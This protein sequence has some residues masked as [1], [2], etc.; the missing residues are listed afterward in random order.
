MQSMTHERQ[1]KKGIVWSAIERFSIQGVQFFLSI[2][3]ARLI[4]PSAFGLIA[5]IGVFTAIAQTFVDSG[6][7]SALIQKQKRK[8]EDYSTVFYFNII[9]GVGIC[10]LFILSA[11]YIASFYDEP[12]LEKLARWLSLNLIINALSIIHRTKLTILLDFK[13]QAIASLISVVI[14]GVLGIFFAYNGYG[15]WALVIQSLSYSGINTILLWFIVKWRP[16]FIFSMDSFHSL[17]KF[18]SKLLIG[19]IMHTLYLNLYTLAIGKMFSP[20][21]VGYYNRANSLAVFP[22]LNITN[23]V[24]RVSYPMQSRIQDD[25][26]ELKKS[27]IQNIRF[28]I[29]IISPIM[30]I[31]AVLSKPFIVCILTEK[32]LPAAEL[33]S[34]LCIAYMWQ[35]IMYFNWQL[36]NVKG[37]SDLSLKSEILKKSLALLILVITLPWGIKVMC[38]GLLLYSFVDM[39][40]I[41]FFIRKVIDVSYFEQ[42]NNYK[43]IIGLSL[44]TGIIVFLFSNLVDPLWIKLI[45][46]ILVGFAFY[47]CCSYLFQIKELSYFIQLFKLK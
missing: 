8:D 9:V 39:G 20:L 15:V 10:V 23:I 43:S 24:S 42:L 34:I 7:S 22:S 19:G 33:L 37:R 17:F 38:W 18:G 3:L 30:V 25:S 45:G 6:F 21:E 46:G 27:F 35:P 4:L 14:S 41:F 28:S 26:S 11:P 5:M 16:L 32:W 12:I 31:L 40:I 2:V 29:Y 36:L 13:R 1:V 44:L 47:I